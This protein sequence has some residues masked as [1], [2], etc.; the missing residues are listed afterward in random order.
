MKNIRTILLC[1]ILICAFS[2][3]TSC[4]EEE[5]PPH[6]HTWGEWVEIVKP[7][8]D[9]EGQKECFCTECKTYK[10]ETIEKLEHEYINE[11]VLA[12]ATCSSH[13]VKVYN[14]K[15]CGVLKEEE[16]SEN[17]TCTDEGYFFYFF[18]NI[19]LFVICA[20]NCEINFNN[21]YFGFIF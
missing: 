1:M 16:I 15:H 10:R 17:C 8:C 11:E 3:L 5:Q 20:D 7:T 19:V 21:Y 12:P 14:C 4:K 9:A 6:E 13:G 2:F 18:H